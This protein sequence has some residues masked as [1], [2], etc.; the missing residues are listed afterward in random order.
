MASTTGA[1]AAPLWPAQ[2]ISRWGVQ[3]AYCRWAVGM[4]AATVLGR[5]LWGER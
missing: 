3:A 5:P 2:W 4:W 1:T